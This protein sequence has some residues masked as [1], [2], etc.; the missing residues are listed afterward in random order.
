MVEDR[1][2]PGSLLTVSVG[3]A[4]KPLLTDNG[5]T[6][7]SN[8][9]I[10]MTTLTFSQ[11]QS[12]PA[13]MLGEGYVREY[14][15]ATPAPLHPV[16]AAQPGQVVLVKSTKTGFIRVQITSRNAQDDA[17]TGCSPAMLRILDNISNPANAHRFS[18]ES[19]RK[20]FAHIEV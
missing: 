9:E 4:A 18:K 10:A 14:T 5:I 2:S 6:V 1:Y 7:I 15:R 3:V 12:I 17:E 8:T 13:G 16:H 11:H 19:A 20:A